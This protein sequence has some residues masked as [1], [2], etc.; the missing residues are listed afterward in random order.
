V[1]TRL[2]WHD[3]RQ[4]AHA[5][6]SA[7]PSEV[8]PLQ[9]CIRRRLADDLLSPGDLPHFASSAMDGWLTVG[10]GPWTI[11]DAIPGPGQA[12]LVVTGGIVPEGTTAVLRSESGS[13]SGQHIRAVGTEATRG[14]TLI[15]AS[16]VLNPAHLALAAS[17][18]ADSLLVQAV[19]AVA[20]V[21]T[22]DEVVTEGAPGTGQVRDSF[23]IQLPALFDLLGAH[24]EHTSR[25]GD[26]LDSI[27]QAIVSAPAP[28]VV[29]T[30]GTGASS[31]DHL[32]HALEELDARIIIDGVAM[33]PGGPTLVGELP[34]GRLIACLPGNP[35][36]A[37]I[38]AI[39][40]CEP[41]IAGLAGRPM[42]PTRTIEAPEVAGR[43]GTT[44]LLPYSSGD[45]GIGISPWV[46]SGM[47]R[48]LA[49][50]AGLLVVPEAGTANGRSAESVEL[51]WVIPARS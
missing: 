4:R 7:L 24:V 21:L 5:A 38:A 8:V 25:R 45:D 10:D 23:G 9:H 1:S 35:L 42:R 2:G 41:L 12:R 19:P 14:E 37:M 43:H 51:P 18:G 34:D 48:G 17:T 6:A 15:A 26:H 44:T 20:L 13:A 30:G 28:L 31:A 40:I 39:T 22:G 50:A 49:A 36:A 46:G 47:M 27:A 32:R 33:R 11:T 3:A 16:T 29:S